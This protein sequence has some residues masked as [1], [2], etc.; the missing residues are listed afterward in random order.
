MI[1]QVYNSYFKINFRKALLVL[2]S[3]VASK[4]VYSQTYSWDNLDLRSNLYS[5]RENEILQNLNF[6][7]I[8]TDLLNEISSYEPYSNF[9]RSYGI[10]KQQ[11]KKLLEEVRRDDNL[12]TSD[13]KFSE[14]NLKGL[15]FGRAIFFHL[16]LLKYGVSKNSIKKIYAVGAID[17]E[18]K[19]TVWQ[20]HMATIVKDIDSNKWWV[21][22]TN[23]LQPLTVDEWM[24]QIKR[25]SLDKTYRLFREP[26]IDKTKSIRFYIT[27]PN[28]IGPSGW[29]YN[30]KPGGLFDSFYNDYFK[31][32]FK[33]IN[34]KSIPQTEKFNQIN[35]RL[36][37]EALF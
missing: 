15:C 21:L 13:P 2:L 29:E 17:S 16:M 19:D 3:F 11:A 8:N 4:T 31:E 33:I 32:V 24:H 36:K 25:R 30:I 14:N 6:D 1:N 28:K 22:D 27:N 23:F 35:S 20:F 9:K 7:H 12:L 26:L 34:A 10:S 37:C 5:V 18:N